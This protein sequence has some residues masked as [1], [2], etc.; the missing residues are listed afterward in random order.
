MGGVA[1]QTV[2]QKAIAGMQYGGSTV[3]AGGGF[4]AFLNEN[5]QAIGA[6]VGLG[7]LAVA[8]AGFGIGWIY[9]HKH[10]KLEEM[11]KLGDLEDRIREKIKREFDL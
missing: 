6:L 10:Y 11:E 9:K 8:V 5:A 7:G 4:M 3:A 2:A 1:E